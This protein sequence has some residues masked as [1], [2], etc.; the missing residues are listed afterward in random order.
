[1]SYLNLKTIL[2]QSANQKTYL[3]FDSSSDL[4]KTQVLNNCKAFY[5]SQKDIYQLNRL[6]K[7]L[8][9]I[10][11]FYPEAEACLLTTQEIDQ[12]KKVTV[13]GQ[14]DFVCRIEKKD[15]AYSLPILPKGI[16][17]YLLKDEKV[18]INFVKPETLEFTQVPPKSEPLSQHNKP[19]IHFLLPKLNFNFKPLISKLKSFKPNFLTKKKQSSSPLPLSSPIISHRHHQKLSQKRLYSIVFAGVFLLLLGFAIGYGSYQ[20]QQFALSQAQ[21]Q[22]RQDVTY[23]LKQAQILKDLNPARAKTLLS[24]SQDLLSTYQNQNALTQDLLELSAQIDATYESVSQLFRTPEALFYDLGLITSPFTAKF[25]ALS[26]KSLS[27]LDSSRQILL[28][29]DIDKKNGQIIAGKAEI[30]PSSSLASIDDW[31]FTYSPA[32]IKVFD[33]DAKSL[34]NSFKINKLHLDQ[35]IGY[36]VNLYGLDKSAGQVYRFRS[37]GKTLSPAQPFFKDALDLSTINSFSIDGSLWLLDNGGGV[38]QFTQGIKDAYYPDFGLDLPL[39]N[40][41]K[42]YTDEYCQNLYIWDPDNSRLVVISKSGFY[43]G[44]YSN[45]KIKIVSDFVVSEEI[46]KIL[47]A[48]D[49]KI[50]SIDLK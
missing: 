1:M 43:Q 48:K 16:S 50:F 41:K 34:L 18:I 38:H 24:E 10:L 17:G 4:D 27:I 36:T 28:T 12:R 31:V 45:E 21:D 5:R 11:K 35:I 33:K 46:G 29:L 3:L 25:L 13:C 20:K 8:T 6:Q 26:D 2:D 19:K 47:L 39:A 23:R 32:G 30:E 14:G 9:Q 15:H 22:L 44:Q 40:P 7:T 49:D 42:L 37:Q